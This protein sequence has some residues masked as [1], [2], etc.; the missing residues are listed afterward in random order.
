MSLFSRSGRHPEGRHRAD[1]NVVAEALAGMHVPVD[2]LDEHTWNVR[3]SNSTAPE[4]GATI[5]QHPAMITIANEI[6]AVES[7][8]SAAAEKLLA[9]DHD[10]NFAKIGLDERRIILSREV[11]RDT[12]DNEGLVR[13][14]STFN[15][16]HEYAGR[17]VLEIFRDTGGRL[18]PGTRT[19]GRD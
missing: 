8:P 15:R 4:Y 19:A 17:K 10:M 5:R 16:C 3:L 18:A 11:Q 7:M 2:R 12:V 13:E 6:A 9:L 14:L 1:F